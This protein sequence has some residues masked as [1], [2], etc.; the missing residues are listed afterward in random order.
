MEDFATQPVRW[1]VSP[2][3]ENLSE[4]NSFNFNS[5]FKRSKSTLLAW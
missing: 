2:R 1:L 3:D 4:F 5:K